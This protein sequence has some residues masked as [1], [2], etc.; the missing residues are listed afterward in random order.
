MRLARSQTPASTSSKQ[1][2][3]QIVRRLRE[4]APWQRHAI[5]CAEVSQQRIAA[6]LAQAVIEPLHIRVAARLSALDAA[7]EQVM[8]QIG[9]AARI[10]VAVDPNAWYD[11]AGIVGR[12]EIGRASRMS[13]PQK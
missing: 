13:L 9:I 10:R 7:I 12:P 8:E 2:A 3:A 11:G 1:Q 5:G 6:A 4:S